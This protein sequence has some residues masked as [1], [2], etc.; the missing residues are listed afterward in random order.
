MSPDRKVVTLCVPRDTAE[1]AVVQGLLAEAGI[2]FVSKNVQLQNLVGY[3]QIGGLNPVVGPIEIFVAAEDAE[4]AREVLAV[5]VGS[6]AT[7]VGPADSC[8]SCGMPTAGDG[9]CEQC[10]SSVQPTQF[11]QTEAGRVSDLDEAAVS[12]LG[13]KIRHLSFAS[14][15]LSFLWA[16]GIGSALGVFFGVRAVMLSRAH[17]TAHAPVGLAVPGIALGVLGLLATLVSLR[18]WVP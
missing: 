18:E 16:G 14:F 12:E 4:R 6:E 2:E 10:G 17:S 5:P 13:R 7:D 15:L 1:F 3:G 9:N 8:P 11:M